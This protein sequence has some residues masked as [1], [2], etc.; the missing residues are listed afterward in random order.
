MLIFVF[1]SVLSFFPPLDYRLQES[2]DWSLLFIPVS[3]EL[4]QSLTHNR[5][6][7]MCVE[8]VN[9]WVAALPVRQAET[10]ILW[11]P[12][13][14]LVQLLPHALPKCFFFSFSASLYILNVSVFQLVIKFSLFDI[15][16]F[17]LVLSCSCLSLP[18]TIIFYHNIKVS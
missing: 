8:W 12:V 15:S 14:Y 7:K 9:D 5:H 4:R 18:H 16:Y 1:I 10:Q 11:N 2:K 17:Y 6:L 3:L 13:L